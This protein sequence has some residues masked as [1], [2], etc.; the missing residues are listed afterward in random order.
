MGMLFSH[1][2]S[3]EAQEEGHPGKKNLGP[4]VITTLPSLFLILYLEDNQLNYLIFPFPLSF[5][6]MLWNCLKYLA[7]CKKKNYFIGKGKEWGRS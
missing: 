1:R 5:S 2:D 6:S 7:M 3:V 4:E